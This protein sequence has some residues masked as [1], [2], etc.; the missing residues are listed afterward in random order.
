MPKHP[1]KFF[2]RTLSC[3]TL[4]KIVIVIQFN[5]CL[6]NRLKERGSPKKIKQ[7][8]F[9]LTEAGSQGSSICETAKIF[10][11]FYFLLV[12]DSLLIILTLILLLKLLNQRLLFVFRES[13]KHENRFV[14]NVI[15]ENFMKKN[16]SISAI[17][18]LECV[19]AWIIDLFI[20]YLNGLSKL[21][22][23]KYH[24]QYHPRTQKR[25]FY[26]IIH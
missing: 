12:S 8:L 17:T 4:H 3:K 15:L 1:N 14:A 2:L 18:L 25:K 7:T 13:V 26:S 20:M 5:V 24:K 21:P 23:G 11:V 16:I 9:F 19:Q 6:A 22:P 10:T